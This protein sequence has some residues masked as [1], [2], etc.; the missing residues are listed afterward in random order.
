[1]TMVQQNQIK[2]RERVIKKK[3]VWQTKGGMNVLLEEVS[4]SDD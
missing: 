4:M 2:E 3:T 1:M